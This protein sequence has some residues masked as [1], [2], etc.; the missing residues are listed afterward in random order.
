M[1][2]RS[3]FFAFGLLFLSL[4]QAAC[5]STTSKD[6]QNPL[7]QLEMLEEA[8]APSVGVITPMERSDDEWRAMLTDM[9]YT[10]LRN[11]GTERAFTG[12]LLENKT[13]GVYTCSGC[14]LELF[15]SRHKFR[16]G[17]GWPS[18]WQPFRANHV[19]ASLDGA[20]GMTRIEVH[21]ARCGGHLGH[22]FDDGPKPT[23]LRYCINSAALDFLE[24]P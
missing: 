21:C 13:Q 6:Q 23:G 3:V 7:D 5:Q 8:V 16:S 2:S 12:D 19:G 11:H 20:Y 14:G 10:V 9:E 15:A 22:V 1:I 4:A 24:K 18:F 17:T